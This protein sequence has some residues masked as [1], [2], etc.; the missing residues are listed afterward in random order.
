MVKINFYGDTQVIEQIPENFYDFM[1]IIGSLFDANADQ[2][3][4]EYTSDGKN[5]YLLKEDSYNNFFLNGNPETTV[6]IYLNY[7]ETNVYKNQQKEDKKINEQE[8]VEIE[9]LKIEEK[10]EDDEDI[11]T[12]SKKNDNNEIKIPEITKDM[13][14][15]SIVKQV[16]ENM[17]KSRILLQ[18]KEEEEKRK[19]K[20]KEEK[21]KEEIKGISDQ[22]SNLI[23]NRLDNLK[24]EL[25]NESQVKFS[26]I[27]SESQLNVKNLLENNNNND[28]NKEVVHSLEEHPGITCSKCGM[29]PIKGNRYCCVYCNNVNYCEQCEEI[30]GLKHG[31]PLY[32]FKL[33]IK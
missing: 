23:T 4:L 3:I 15:N 14:I 12:E 16:K 29:G 1:G 10:E 20:E 32:K 17:Q 21:E 22:I 28:E 18:Q 2:L 25:I 5:Y 33:R 27:M 24:Q 9:Q 13:V 6:N 19:K 31:H 26:Q 7:E 30:D 11:N 8:T